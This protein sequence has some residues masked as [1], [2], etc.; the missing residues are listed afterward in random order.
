MIS[1]QLNQQ[2]LYKL[3]KKLQRM[4]NFDK[5]FRKEIIK[6][7]KSVA[8]LYVTAARNNIK[9]YGATIVVQ[10]KRSTTVIVP[11]GTLRRSMGV[12]IPKNAAS[13]VAAGP[14][15]GT[16]GKRLKYYEDGW[17]AHFVEYGARP[18][19]FGGKQMTRNVGVFKRTQQMVAPIIGEAMA[20][21]MTNMI[22]TKGTSRN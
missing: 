18:D 16:L 4:A 12:W 19:E 15:A 7:S 22:V 1:L 17:F 14:R 10:R 9:D 2:E 3:E 6:E 11:S 21:K 20:R 8:I 5:V 13:H